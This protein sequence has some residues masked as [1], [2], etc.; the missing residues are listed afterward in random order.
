MRRAG[1]ALAAA[2]LLVLA[3]AAAADARTVRVFAGGPRYD[4]SWVQDRAAYRAKLLAL[5]DARERGAAG[6][7]AVRQGAGDVAARLLGPSDRARPA[8]TARDLVT[9]PEDLGLLAAF[10]G[11]RG[12]LARSAPDLTT[13]I[14]GLLATYAPQIA[15][16]TATFPELAQRPFPPT[17]ALAL[18]LTD[19]FGRVVVETFAELADRLD[20]YL[21]AGVAMAQH[22]RVVCTSKAQMPEL[23]GGVGC[24]VESPARVALL[25]TIDDDRPYA[26]EATSA[27]PSTQALVFDPDGKLVAKQVKTYLT[28][29]E[30]P[31]QL[32]LVPGDVSRGLSAVRTP[33][34]VLGIVTS[35][36]AWMP[37]VTQKLDQAGVE[38]LVQ[39]EFFV[40]DTVRREGQWAP[41]T[42][43]SSG[44]AALLRHPSITAYALP[45]L[46]GNLFDFSADAQH[47]VAVEPRSATARPRQA[48]VGQPPAPGMAA[49]SPWVV[50]DPA[51]PDEPM[52]ERRARLGVAG[53]ALLPGGPRAGAMVEDVVAVDVRV[54]ETPERRRVVPRRRGVGP[55][56][57]NRLL[58]PSARPQRNVALAAR[59]RRAYAAFEERGPGGRWRVRVAR[60]A[61][62][63]ARWRAPVGVGD[64]ALGDQW[65]PALAAG[66]GREVW[67]AWQQRDRVLVARSVDGGRRFGAPAPIDATVPSD[68]HQ[69]HPSIAATGPGSAVVAWVDER[70]RV[71]GELGLPRAQVHVATLR[72]GRPAGDARAL[73]GDGPVAA[74]ATSMAHAWAPSVTARGGDVLVA[75][76]DFATY[77]W[78]VRARRSSDGGRTFGGAEPTG[79][80]APQLEQLAD[81]PQAALT[82]AG[83]P[84]VAFAD[85]RKDP[86]TADRPHR[87]QDVVVAPVG[88]SAVQVDGD[89]DAQRPAFAPAI[90]ALPR[91][92]AV[93]A[94]QGH[95]HG[96]A[97]VLAARVD[98]EGRALR[99][100]RVDDTRLAGSGQWRPAVAAG[101]R[102]V[103]VAWEDD[104]GGPPQVVVA[105]ARASRLG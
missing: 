29:V 35:K 56:S 6:A 72:D 76:L 27:K 65:W 43:L 84:L 39:P 62:E 77:D 7:T 70:G 63:G 74:L 53:E 28:P 45:E 90:A 19:T 86:T 22:W 80:G 38:V 89:G 47:A 23:P 87:L 105:R 44:Y 93:V 97:D 103:V 14:L 17:R 83:K 26:Y 102:Q 21:V 64:P 8:A 32:D 13:S 60:S 57:D 1:A 48:L 9:L 25:R 71:G 95:R 51:W 67:L 2:L 58:A 78:R 55:F 46:V 73:S 10:T 101:P 50:P 16:Y 31:G 96:P 69:W 79:S 88:G 3:T 81:H 34:G 42:L 11:T 98:D 33:V 36:D 68:V 18:A 30:L 92:G 15:T 100:L 12:A 5:L 40:G 99:V 52:A 66:P 20:A 54:G 49:V 61:D 85:W 24:D 91:G 104:R 75:W 4:A 41:D 82:A 94:W 59:G 37:D